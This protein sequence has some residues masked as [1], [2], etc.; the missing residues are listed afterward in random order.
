[1]DL[2]RLALQAALLITSVSALAFENEPTG[3][4]GIEW[5]TKFEQVAEQ[6]TQTTASQDRVFYQRKGDKLNFGEAVLQDITYMF[7]KGEFQGVMIRSEAGVQNQHALKDA[8]TAQFGF[9]RHPNRYME[10][11]YWF[12]PVTWI[13]LDCFNS[14]KRCT[15]MIRSKAVID[16]E[17][18]D[19]KTAAAGAKKDI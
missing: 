2:Y 8:V 11:V 3:F 14:T 12:G 10:R 19:K 4:R 5:G 1:M 7:Y 13:S 18:A 17:Q 6:F 9:G 15:L 16:R